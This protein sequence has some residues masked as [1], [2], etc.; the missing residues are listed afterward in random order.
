VRL[1][2]HLRLEKPPSCW[3]ISG[4]GKRGLFWCIVVMGVYGKKGGCRTLGLVLSVWC[5]GALGGLWV[6]CVSVIWCNLILDPVRCK[7]A[8]LSGASPGAGSNECPTCGS[9]LARASGVSKTQTHRGKARVGSDTYERKQKREEKKNVSWFPGVGG[10]PV[11]G[12][13]KHTPNPATTTQQQKKTPTETK[14]RPPHATRQHNPA[15]AP[16][17]PQR[18]RDPPRANVAPRPA[19]PPPTR[20]TARRRQT[21]TGPRQK[22]RACRNKRNNPSDRFRG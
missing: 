17:T 10:K 12:G 4:V 2:P 5:N 7:G 20:K 14:N 11:R 19:R 3:S 18:P 15:R 9:M 13:A 8:V 6:G 21:P 16:K 1:A 22:S